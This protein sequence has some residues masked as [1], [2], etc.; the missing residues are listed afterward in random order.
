MFG[1]Q[2]LRVFVAVVESGGIVAA[3]ERLCRTPSAVSMALKQLEEDIGTPL[4]Q[5]GRKNTITPMGRILLDEGRDLLAHFERCRTFVKSAG[6]RERQQTE[7]A[8]T[9][10]FSVSLLAEVVRDLESLPSPIRLRARDMNSFSVCEAVAANSVKIGIGHYDQPVQGLSFLPLFKHS[11]ELVCRVDSLLARDETPISWDELAEFPFLAHDSYGEIRDPAFLSWAAKANVQPSNAMTV[12]AMV[13]A[14]I[15]VTILSSLLEGY[16]DPTIKFR[17]LQ[18]PS[19]SQV[20]G[21]IYRSGERQT[22]ATGQFLGA[23]D[24]VLQCNKDRFRI[25]LLY[26]RE[27]LLA[28]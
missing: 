19:A 16:G 23:L 15:G 4:F 13:K 11:L 6:S 12:F 10:G 18:D 17:A 14:D 5:K 3:A 7:I 8:C 25:R 2:A 22:L 27:E 24:R 21:V 9:A 20:V 26:N 28:I 1:I